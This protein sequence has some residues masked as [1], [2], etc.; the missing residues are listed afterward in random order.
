MASDDDTQKRSSNELDDF[1]KK[2]EKAR[3]SE[4]S[5][6]LWKSNVNRPPS[7]A[8]GL[9]FRVSVEL[10]SAVAVGLAIGWGIDWVLE[11]RPWAMIVFII[12]GFI[13]G[14]MNVYRVASGMS[15][16]KSQGQKDDASDAE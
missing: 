1:G 6:R 7:S 5:R 8:L 12:L 4:K 13:A 2:L 10:V 14:V 3:E 16:A 15:A 9:A 11:S